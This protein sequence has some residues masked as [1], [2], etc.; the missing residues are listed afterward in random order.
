MRALA[1][2]VNVHD[3]VLISAVNGRVLWQTWRDRE[4]GFS[5]IRDL[6]RDP[7]IEIL[8]QL[9]PP[10]PVV[11]PEPVTLHVPLATRRWY[12]HRPV[13]LGL[14]AAIVA[15]IVGGY[16]W[17]HYK[18]PDRPWNPNITGPGTGAGGGP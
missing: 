5:A 9:A 14:G 10:P 13:Q 16:L 1:A 7:P 4:P 11:D 15:A 3:A 18:E 12:Q 2:F 17:V 6:G 8:K